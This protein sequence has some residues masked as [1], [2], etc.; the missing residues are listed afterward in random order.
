MRADEIETQAAE[1]LARRD[2][3]HWTPQQQLEMEAWI[4][5][6]TA[7]RIAWLRLESV[8]RRAD[9][10]SS[11]YNPECSAVPA[12]S[13]IQQYSWSIAAGVMLLVGT[14]WLTAI[15]LREQPARYDT[16]LGQSTSL[17]LED[18]TRVT[19]NTNT[20]LRA[21]L[22]AGRRVVWLDKG[23][24][25]FDVTHEARRPFIV[26]AGTRRVTVLGTRFSVRRDDNGQIQV[27]VADGRVQVD[28]TEGTT[29]PTIITRN[30]SLLAAGDVVQ[31]SHNT[32]QQV[33]SKLSWRQ[34]RL[35]LDQMTLSQAAQEF[36]RYNKRQLIVTD[37]VAAQL[38]L[39]GSFNVDN[40]DGFARLLQQGMGLKV[41]QSGDNIKISR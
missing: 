8:W 35:I 41:E 18:G 40:I 14:A 36:N 24:A 9:R 33:A 4:N 2:G 3:D 23:E 30:D 34:G 5:T 13:V 27:T 38:R 28:S 21:K 26:E 22:V 37:P 20:R 16:L 12:T 29:T 31:V 39:G 17:A 19:L 7:H 10:L 15:G 11:L 32:E 1:W 25:Y 6:S